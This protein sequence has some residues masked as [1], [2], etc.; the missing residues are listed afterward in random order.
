MSEFKTKENKGFIWDFL[1]EQKLFDGISPSY[2]KDIQLSFEQMIEN[3]DIQYTSKGLID[4]NKEVIRLMVG[5]LELYKKQ[6]Q[7][8]LQSQQQPRS[9]TTN[10]QQQNDPIIYKAEDIHQDRQSKM[11]IAFKQKQNEFNSFKMKSPQDISF[12]DKKDE[13][14]GDDMDNLIAK[15]IAMREKQLNQLLETQNP[16]QLNR[17]AKWIDNGNNGNNVNASGKVINLKI[18]G[19]TELND[20][21]VT[22]PSSIQNGSTRA[23]P[24][25]SN[26]RDK[27]VS[28]N[29]ADNIVY[30]DLSHT[31]AIVEQKPDNIELNF[32]NRLKRTTPEP[33]MNK[34]DIDE[35]KIK[36]DKVLFNQ[37]EIM[38]FL[39]K[40]Q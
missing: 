35:L 25:S 37:E 17:A 5:Q 9:K 30:H 12:A 20:K 2:Q 27:K 8:Q 26:S 23:S 29:D 3:V 13:P 1:N 32:L 7:A 6:T 24:I 10:N 19:D 11:D 31:D 39:Q 28:F 36:I 16:D 40:M 22:L 14:I 15:T 4:K 38:K 21:I 34:N 33:Q 18:G